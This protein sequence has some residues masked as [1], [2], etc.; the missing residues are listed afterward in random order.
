[1]GKVRMNRKEQSGNALPF[2]EQPRALLL[3]RITGLAAGVLMLAAPFF[4]WRVVVV[5]ADIRVREGFSL[6]DVLRKSFEKG[7]T[8]SSW[9]KFAVILCSLLFLLSGVC[10]LY[11]AFRDQIMPEKFRQ[12]QHLPERFFS[13]FRLI[14]HALPVVLSLTSVVI[15]ERTVFYDVLYEK[16]ILETYNSWE[17][18]MIG[19][20]HEWKLPGLGCWLFYLGIKAYLFAEGFRYLIETLN[21]EE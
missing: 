21:E 14:S 9:P 4:R 20:Y 3:C 6:F 8:D 10:I 11:F 12:M 15:M 13:R 1:M 18:L 19:S 7:I 16:K 17:S 5:K 2:Y